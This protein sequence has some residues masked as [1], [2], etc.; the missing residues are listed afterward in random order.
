ME[1]IV[2]DPEALG[3]ALSEIERVGCCFMRGG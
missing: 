1:Q 2:V 3:C